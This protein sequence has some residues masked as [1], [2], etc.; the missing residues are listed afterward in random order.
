MIYLWLDSL[1]R[2]CDCNKFAWSRGALSKSWKCG[3]RGLLLESWRGGWTKGLLHE[4]ALGKSLLKTITERFMVASNCWILVF[5]S[6]KWP[7]PWSWQT[8]SSRSG[9]MRWQY[10]SLPMLSS[11]QRK[12]SVFFPLKGFWTKTVRLVGF[13]FVSVICFVLFSVESLPLILWSVEHREILV[14]A[15]S[16]EAFKVRWDGALRTLI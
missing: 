2:E 14:N 5:W 9:Q 1:D 8:M 10:S 6:F 15:P 16:L 11:T 12:A 3:G 4:S 7:F 13:C